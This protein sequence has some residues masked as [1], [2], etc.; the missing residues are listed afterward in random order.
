MEMCWLTLQDGH[1]F[2]GIHESIF[3]LFRPEGPY[4]YRKGLL[5]IG[6]DYC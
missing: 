5:L 2:P 6:K 3:L 1:V 4:L